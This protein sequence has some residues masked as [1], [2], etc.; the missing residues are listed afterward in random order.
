M[1][2]QASHG[3]VEDVMKEVGDRRIQYGHIVEG[4]ARGVLGVAEPEYVARLHP[5]M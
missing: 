3:N 2:A 1:T 4:D 5:R